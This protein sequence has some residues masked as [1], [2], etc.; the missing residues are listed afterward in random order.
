LGDHLDNP[1]LRQKNIKIISY[2]DF[3]V[4]V[5]VIAIKISFNL[6]EESVLFVNFVWCVDVYKQKK[7]GADFISA[8]L[9][10]LE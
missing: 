6:L 4:S 3:A 7:S 2:D 5:K 10:Y 1:N 9:A 8:D